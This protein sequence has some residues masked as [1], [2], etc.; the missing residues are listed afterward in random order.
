MDSTHRAT[1]FWPKF[2]PTISAPGPSWVASLQLKFDQ[3]HCQSR[4][5]SAFWRA[6]SLDNN[7]FSALLETKVQQLNIVAF[8]I[9]TIRASKTSHMMKFRRQFSQDHCPTLL[10]VVA[11]VNNRV[12]STTW[13]PVFQRCRN[14][15]WCAIESCSERIYRWR[16]L[17][18]SSVALLLLGLLQ[19]GR[20]FG[21][22]KKCP[23]L[24]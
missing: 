16:W 9:G 11:T 15:T 20:T 22:W 4:S 13:R 24:V 21:W 23:L 14:G 12:F 3:S 10:S 8:W 17:W 1:S 2:P 18:G 19:I 6:L 5:N 7:C